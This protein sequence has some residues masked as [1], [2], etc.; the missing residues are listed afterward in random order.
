VIRLGLRLT[1]GGGRE[2]VVRLVITTVAVA[3]GAGLLLVTLAAMNAISAQ[4]TRS[5]WLGTGTAAAPGGPGNAGARAGQPG[6]AAAWWLSSADQFDGQIIY[7]VDV[8]ATGPGAPVPPGI[9]HLPGP[10]QFYAS[11]ALAR[12]LATTPAAELGDRY[13]GRQAGTIGT[14]A[15]PSP[16]S[17]V[18]V[19]GRPAAQLARAPAA[20]KVTSIQTVP[21]SFGIGHSPADLTWILG[22][23]AVALLFPVLILIATATRLAATRREQRFAAMR[24]AGATPAQISVISAVEASCA[25][26]AGAAIGFGLFFLLRPALLHVSFTGQPFTSADL[27]LS[28]ADILLVA[29]GV[30]AASA[31]AARLALRRVQISP[32][33]VSRRVTPPAPRAWRVIPLLAG[34]GDL[35]YFTAAGR[36]GSSS[37]QIRAYLPGFFLIML[38][39]IIAGPW[40]TM[41][42]SR[43]LAHRASRPGTLIAGRRLSDNPRVAFRAISGLIIALFVTSVSVAVITASLD[44]QR[45]SS[46]TTASDTLVDHFYAVAPAQSAGSVPVAS[47][48]VLPAAVLARLRAIPGV[49]G[50]TVVHTDPLTT[51][52]TGPSPLHLTGLAS[53]AQL[54]GT[55][56][57]GRCKTGAGA[58]TV[59]VN[60]A[61][62]LGGPSQSSV[63]RPAT[64]SASRLQQL[65]VQAVVVATNG[66]ITTIERARTI[67]QAAS[68]YLA[69]PV[70]IGAG[71][72]V[73]LQTIADLQHMTDVVIT[74]SL[75]IAG[76]SLAVSVAGGLTERKRPFSLLRLTG[77]PLSVLRRAVVLESA[78]P[79]VMTAVVSAG[80]GFLAAWLFLRSELNLSLRPPGAEYYATTAAGLVVSLAVIAATLPL[81][82]RITG[83]ETARNE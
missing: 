8:A 25:A 56:V 55:P 32:L 76:C 22:I 38:G 51:F 2:S 46:G 41:A 33:G 31:V 73:S 30:P 21:G 80:G 47:V 50:I 9:S 40:L 52:G 15:L 58:A 19:I 60:V 37:G 79:L 18:I 49:R 54:S 26:V 34:I 62:K 57:L 71:N 61:V 70:T 16:D 63:V 1:L 59:T 6:S 27:S 10:G 28:L 81:L 53:C 5:A 35:A 82:S 17:L 66:S 24:L 3:I 72:P 64:I 45:P 74:V 11:P 48:P 68:P 69:P 77:V 39:L 4:N 67:L 7:R 20:T 78:V 75:V 36:P 29:V 43:L 44:A 23:A 83:P 42:G 14:Q 12:L 65:P 13:P